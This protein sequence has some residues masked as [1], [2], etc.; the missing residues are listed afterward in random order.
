MVET[1]L[2]NIVVPRDLG[3]LTEA[4]LKA[5]RDRL[6]SVGCSCGVVDSRLT[7]VIE[8]LRNAGANGAEPQ[9]PVKDPPPQ[10]KREE[11]RREEPRAERPKQDG[12]R[13]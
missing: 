11:P 8:A 12:G 13:K 2:K 4:Q 5:L 6:I 10:P 7:L 9:E 3:V 1:I